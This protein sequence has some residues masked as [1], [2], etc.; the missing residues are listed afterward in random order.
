M[1]LTARGSPTVDS[2]S[3][4]H[5]ASVVGLFELCRK[6]TVRFARCGAAST[7]TPRPLALAEA[8]VYVFDKTLA[9]RSI[10]GMHPTGGIRLEAAPTLF[11]RKS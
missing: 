4:P 11:L 6:V 5:S 1:V 2:A 9:I 8:L 3:E 7:L 10:P